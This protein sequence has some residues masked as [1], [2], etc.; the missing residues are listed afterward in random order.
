MKIATASEAP[1]VI[2]DHA[3]KQGPTPPARLNRLFS[4]RTE[5]QAMSKAPRTG[6]VQEGKGVRRQATSTTST[7]APWMAMSQ[8]TKAKRR[9]RQLRPYPVL[10]P[11]SLRQR[12]SAPSCQRLSTWSHRRTS[13]PP[14]NK[15]GVTKSTWARRTQIIGQESWN[16]YSLSSQFGPATWGL[17]RQPSIGLNSY[18]ARSQSTNPLTG[19]AQ[20]KDK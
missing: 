13:S 14:N 5:L 16:S 18:R 6:P 20:L 3:Q 1:K 8:Q 2:F 17:S 7:K 10:R 4:Q 19:Q 12:S 15:T 9:A 11:T